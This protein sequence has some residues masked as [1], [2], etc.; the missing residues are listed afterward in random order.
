MSSAGEGC[1]LKSLLRLLRNRS[2]ATAAEYTVILAIV[3]CAIAVG[4][5]AL[6]VSISDSVDSMSDRMAEC[7]D[8]SCS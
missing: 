2:G 5:V 3:G 4:A 8:G 6:G 7:G 1:Q